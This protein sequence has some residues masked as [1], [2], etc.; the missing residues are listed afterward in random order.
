MNYMIY[1]H[2]L[3]IKDPKKKI[4]DSLKIVD[5]KEN[6]LERIMSTLS[7]TEKKKFQI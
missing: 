3:N 1:Y 7:T 5:L 6:Y 4:I 2:K